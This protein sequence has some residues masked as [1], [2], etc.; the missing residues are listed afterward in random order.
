MFEATRQIL[1]MCNGDARP[2]ILAV[3]AN[4]TPEWRASCLETGM[5]DFVAKPI[6]FGMLLPRL[7]AL[8]D[9]LRG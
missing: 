7:S 2:V 9:Q 5:E 4:V 3:S 8:S 1:A 6:D